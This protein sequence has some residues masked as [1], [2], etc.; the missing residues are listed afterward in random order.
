M[1]NEDDPNDGFPPHSKWIYLSLDGAMS[2]PSVVDALITDLSDILTEYQKGTGV[3]F[4]PGSIHIIVYGIV[5]EGLL[6][7]RARDLDRALQLFEGL[8]QICRGIENDPILYLALITQK[9]IH[10]QRHCVHAALAVAKKEEVFCRAHGD[11]ERVQESLREQAELAEIID[12]SCNS[13]A[14]DG[15]YGCSE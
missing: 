6:K 4:E 8:E 9:G 7:L 12:T 10:V 1:S 11:I 15:R 2:E 13:V 3:C 14:D 5:Y